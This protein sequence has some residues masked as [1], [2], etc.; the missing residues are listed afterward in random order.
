VI[1]F[2]WTTTI[3]DEGNVMFRPDIYERDAA[4]S[5][6]LASRFRFREKPI[7][8]QDA[9]PGESSL[10]KKLKHSLFSPFNS[11]AMSSPDSIH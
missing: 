3:D 9:V 8:D 2:Y 1:L 5:K 7:L 4:I 11:A 10:E 6:G